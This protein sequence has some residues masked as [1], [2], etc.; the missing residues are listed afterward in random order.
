MLERLILTLTPERG[1]ATTFLSFICGILPNFEKVVKDDITFGFQIIA[2]TIS[3]LVGCLTMV[4][5]HM[6]MIDR[7][8]AKRAQAQNQIS[9]D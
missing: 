1:F 9:E 3:I 6:K 8:R 7:R 2:F 4:H 5:L